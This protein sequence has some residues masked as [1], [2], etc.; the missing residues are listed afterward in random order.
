MMVRSGLLKQTSYFRPQD[1]LSMKPILFQVGPIR[2]KSIRTFDARDVVTGKQDIKE[3]STGP[4]RQALSPNHEA[5]LAKGR[6][7]TLE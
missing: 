4:L 2:N 3:C 7:E 5:G 6:K 1:V